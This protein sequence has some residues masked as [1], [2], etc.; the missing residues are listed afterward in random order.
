MDDL[1]IIKGL[2]KSEEWAVE[3]V[4][5]TYSDRLLKS[6]FSITGDRHTAEEVVQDA[7]LTVCRKIDSFRGTSSLYTWMYRITVNLAKNRTRS[8]WFRKVYVQEDPIKYGNPSEGLTPEDSVIAE[9]NT[10]EIT[11]LLRDLPLIY[12][13]V[14]D[15]YYIQEF[16]ISDMARLLGVSEG[17]IKSRLARARNRLGSLMKERWTEYER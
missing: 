10:R 14:V 11:A 12:R 9:E 8:R 7:L 5:E 4:L 2:K 1:I 3:A 15:L 6:A 16:K 17:T 13:Q